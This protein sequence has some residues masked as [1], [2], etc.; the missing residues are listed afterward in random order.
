M[1][2]LITALVLATAALTVQAADISLNCSF[3]AIDGTTKSQ[4]VQL[5]TTSNGASIGTQ[6]YSLRSFGNSYVLVGRIGD[7]HT[8]NRETLA[9]KIEAFGN[10]LSGSCAVAKSNNKI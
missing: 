8:I 9:Y 10:K 6:Q 3:T 7:E 2:Q 4:S 1:K 5:N